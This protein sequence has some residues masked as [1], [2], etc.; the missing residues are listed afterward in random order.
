LEIEVEGE[1]LEPFINMAMTRG[2]ML[3]DL[4][5]VGDDRLSAKVRV[6]GFFGLRHIA[7]RNR[8][9]LKIRRRQGFPFLAVRL[10]KRKMLLLG[11]LLFVV[12]LSYLSSLVWSID[13]TGNQL[14]AGGD[15]LRVAAREGLVLGTPGWRIDRHRL[16]KVLLQEFPEAAFFSVEAHGTRVTIEVVEK[17]FPPPDD[18][19]QGR[20][21]VVAARSGV[22]ED[23]IV[24]VGEPLVQPGDRVRVGQVLIAGTANA[25][26]I[27][28]ARVWYTVYG[29]AEQVEHRQRKTGRK[30]LRVH[31]S[32]WGK[33]ITLYG[34]REAPYPLYELEQHESRIRDWPASMLWEDIEEV[35]DYTVEHGEAGALD[36]AIEKARAEISDSVMPDSEPLQEK[37]DRV[38]L[39]DPNR[40][41]VRVQLEA[42]EDI[43][44]RRAF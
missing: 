42:R 36:L 40:V 41:R 21:H 31:L 39:D 34:P 35:E 16:E 7:R 20:F 27:V 19:Q 38:P 18:N 4:K 30:A 15:I 14:I 6:S 44:E 11:S 29:E 43:G 13:V 9:R 5:I 8:C 26:G 3:W 25:R 23:V 10:R 32:G 28:R 1:R 17:R 2:I 22:I 24:R 33:D 12:L 37:I